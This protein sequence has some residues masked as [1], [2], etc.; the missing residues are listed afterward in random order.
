MMEKRKGLFVASKAMAE[1]GL[2]LLLPSVRRAKDM[3]SAASHSPSL[4]IIHELT[5]CYSVLISVLMV[6]ISVADVKKKRHKFSHRHTFYSD[7]E[8]RQK[9]TSKFHQ[10]RPFK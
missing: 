2:I 3:I 1:V 10:H 5:L 9:D 7:I 4:D 8:H 6:R